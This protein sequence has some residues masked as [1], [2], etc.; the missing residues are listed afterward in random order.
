MNPPELQDWD[1]A[2]AARAMA[3]D[4]SAAKRLFDML[5]E[6]LALAQRELEQHLQGDDWEAMLAL[7]HKLRGS[8]RLCCAPTLEELA[9][10]LEAAALS[11]QGEVMTPLLHELAQQTQ[12]LERIRLEQT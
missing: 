12:R 1:R 4:A 2:A 8:S 3:N 11:R 7:A 9:G 6:G 10:R 5:V